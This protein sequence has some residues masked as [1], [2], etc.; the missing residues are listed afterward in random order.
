[1]KILGL[2]VRE[3]GSFRQPVALEGL[4]GGLDVLAGPN[5]FGKT[6]LFR[7]LEAAFTVA[8][9]SNRK[10]DR[11]W[12]IPATGGAPVIEVDF[13]ANGARY[14]LNKRYFTG[15]RA[16]LERLDG[17][18][19]LRGADAEDQLAALL[20][21]AGGPDR[22]GLLW[23]GQRQSLEPVAV[24]DAARDGLKGLVAQELSCAVG[25]EQMAAIRN[26]VRERLGA[27]LT[28]GKRLPKGTFKEATDALARLT[29]EQA[30]LG[31]V[32]SQG[33]DRLER[34]A[35][36]AQ[37]QARLADGALKRRRSDRML[38]ARSA[39]EAARAAAD[40]RRTAEEQWKRLDREHSTAGKELAGFD[41][42]TDEVSAVATRQQAAASDAAARSTALAVLTD[43]LTQARSNHDAAIAA[44][45]AAQVALQQLRREQA[46]QQ[47]AAELA[48]LQRRLAEAEAL[49]ERLA[50][51]S[52]MAAAKPELSGPLKQAEAVQRS[53]EG[54]EAKQAAGTAR[55]Q[56]I[57]LAGAKGRIAHDGKPIGS[58]AELA[59]E[60]PLVL[61]IAGVG[62][63]TVT[64]AEIEDVGAVV[65]D[66]A[67]SRAKLA[68]LLAAADA[69]SVAELG[70]HANEQIQ[71]IADHDK[72]TARLEG[73]CPEG[74]LTLRERTA[75]L[76]TDV[77]WVNAA[78]MSSVPAGMVVPRLSQPTVVAQLA[79]AESARQQASAILAKLQSE[80]Q[81]LEI[82]AAKS[83]A[84]QSMLAE[85]Q[86]ALTA[87]HPPDR[88]VLLAAER[89]ASERAR[90]AILTLQALREAEPSPEQ[91]SAIEAEVASATAA[92]QQA[93][94]QLHALA[95]EM[96]SLDSLLERDAMDG[97]EERL[98]E[99]QAALTTAQ[100]RHGKFGSEIAAL[101]LLE[102]QMADVEH[103]TRERYLAP[104]TARL[105]PYLGIVLPGAVLD[106]GDGF[107]TEGLTRDGRSEAMARLSDGTREQIAVLVRLGLGRLLADAG[108]PLPLILDDA[109]VYSDDDRIAASFAALEL[110]AKYHQVIVLTCRAKAFASLGRTRLTLQPWK[111]GEE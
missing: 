54:L 28:P 14:R 60:R 40:K 50:K 13:E 86:S 51:V 87:K 92:E 71:A 76:E 89:A 61:E 59:V 41:Q 8:H 106:L 33:R 16:S 81:V 84:E 21:E 62:R 96:A 29:G 34:L 2:R 110:A 65:A 69:R 98:A 39:A 66:L 70:Q 67:R 90:Q 47:A 56:I 79:A 74:L 95:L 6:T 44:E 68:E 93:S 25:G 91:L 27:L 35:S 72:L 85:R 48:A 58:D 105:A 82:A 31:E 109:L 5:E 55:V 108:R 75:S 17:T 45:Q 57:Y 88:S 23:V 63:I 103:G 4:T 104:V 1:M 9:K 38:A 26:R 97:I 12:M 32:V 77:G 46:G 100:R 43:A 94:A 78:E 49:S 52:R 80:L 20:D 24:G 10:P 107:A 11:D 83:T 73:L 101:E 42:L 53:I 37:E 102:Q 18:L 15:A 19:M 36:L 7:A 64:P 99:C 30:E 22:L 111:I 3:V